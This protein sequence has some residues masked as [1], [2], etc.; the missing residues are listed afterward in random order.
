MWLTGF[1]VP[2]LATLY[3]DKPLKKHTLMQAIARAN[4][5]HEG[6]TNGL[7]VDYCGILKHLRQALATFAGTR[8]TGPAEGV[9]PAK[10]HE[11]LLAELAEAIQQVR[12]FLDEA[13]APLDTVITE[14]GFQR[15]R[16]I[17]ACKEAA[18]QNDRTRKRLE[19]MCREVFR[20]F[21]ACITVPGVN[22]HRGKRDAINIV[23]Q[24]LRRDRKQAD[25]TEIMRE[26]QGI[27]DEAI[28]VL[29]SGDG[30]ES[31]PFDISRIDFDK[32]ESEFAKSEKKKTTV[33]NLKTAIEQRLQRL[34]KG[35]PLRTDL[36]E[37]YERIVDE[38]N[39]EMDRVTIERTFERLLEFVK[40]LDD[41]E[42]RA[43]REGL[44][45]ESLAL[46]DLLRKPDLSAAEIKKIKNVAVELLTTLKAEKLQIHDWRDKEATRDAVKMEIRNYLWD[47]QIGLPDPA[48]SDS[49][50]ETKTEAVFRHIHYAYPHLPSPVYGERAA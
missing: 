50:V 25:I 48:Y 17:V 16:A 34:M 42:G 13:G 5:V 4:R 33:Q 26:L 37:H 40:E 19:I 29:P 18:N 15:I 6:K 21:K 11:E 9:E 8:N 1:D 12:D 43:V 39:R 45:E 36:Q 47:D 24:S 32:L 28:R 3:L 46:F 2:S 35:N 10:P 20:R 23:Y 14:T 44:D 31:K 7:I 41:E 49:D 27:V 22:E 30:P 38:Y